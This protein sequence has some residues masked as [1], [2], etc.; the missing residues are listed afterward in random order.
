L[1]AADDL[2]RL[3]ALHPILGLL[4]GVQWILLAAA[5]TARHVGR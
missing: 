4:H 1:A 5:H 3:A 2:R